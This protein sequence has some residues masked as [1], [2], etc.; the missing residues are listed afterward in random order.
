ME[1]NKYKRKKIENP[2]PQCPNSIKN[3]NHN[4]NSNNSN[5]INFNSNEIN[6]NNN[7]LNQEDSIQNNLLLIQR[8]RLKNL[9]LF[10]KQIDEQINFTEETIKSLE[11]LNNSSISNKIPQ[12]KFKRIKNNNFDVLDEIR[13]KKDLEILNKHFEEETKFMKNK[14]EL[15][16]KIEIEKKKKEIENERKKIE[17]E[18]NYYINN[19]KEEYEDLINKKNEL[20]NNFIEKEKSKQILEIVNENIKKYNN[21][22]DFIINDYY[23]RILNKQMNKN[24]SNKTNLT[25]FTTQK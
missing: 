1:K 17:K 6:N 7:N 5:Q 20:E 9:I 11:N 22:Q 4:F 2:L 12:N 19:I 10:I 3:L 15:D 13:F 18:N 16:Y 21:L 24:F 14:L 25:N 8:N 23:G